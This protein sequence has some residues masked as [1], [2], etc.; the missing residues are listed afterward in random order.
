MIKLYNDDCC[1]I[2]PTITNESVD[3]VIADIPYGI[4]IASW[5]V[6]HQNK[7]SA[8]GGCTEHQ[9][10][11]TSFKTR[12]KPL[13]GWSK[14]DKNIP[15]EYENWC[16]T[17]AVELMRVTK[18]G[19]PILIFC[20][21]RLQHR[22]A[23]ALENCGFIIRDVLIWE[24]DRC[25]AKAQHI[26]NVL[27]KRGIFDSKYCNYRLGNLAPFYEPIIFAM[28]PY[29][30]TLTDCVINNDI[31][32]FMG[33][34][35][36]IPSNIIRID[37]NKK[38]KYHETEKPVALIEYLIKLFSINENHTILDFTMGSGTTGVACLKLHRNFIGIEKDEY[39]FNIATERL[40]GTV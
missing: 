32:G 7:N 6:L 26:N 11:H 12:G 21:R 10:M 15:Y 5:D 27:N 16:K 40:F 18:E 4:N 3:I 9:F 33:L 17:W 25:N 29:S 1:K 37:T 23:V 34:N 35:N 39:Y 14:A 30:K 19:S 28:H 22:V 20:G 38:N 24:K 8:L 13:N 2:L 36:T 31:G